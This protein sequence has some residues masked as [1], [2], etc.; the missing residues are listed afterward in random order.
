MMAFLLKKA[1]LNCFC[2]LNLSTDFFKMYSMIVGI[3]CDKN[4][5]FGESMNNIYCQESGLN[6]KATGP[7]D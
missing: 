7:G 1:V 4:N 3:S 6:S 2:L 5:F